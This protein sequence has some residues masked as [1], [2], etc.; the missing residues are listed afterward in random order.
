MSI[1]ENNVFCK[2]KSDL[3]KNR[4]FI[5]DNLIVYSEEK[6]EDE[7]SKLMRD[8]YIEMSN[9]NLEFLESNSWEQEMSEYKFDDI[10]EYE[11]WLCGV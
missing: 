1:T 6:F 11:K 3:E 4:K 5:E 7:F 9:I 10:N 8:G 2:I